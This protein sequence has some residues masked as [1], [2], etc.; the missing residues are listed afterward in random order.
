MTEAEGTKVI[1]HPF[2][3]GLK[4]TQRG[5]R[6]P[7]AS[8][9]PLKA[10]LVGAVLPIMTQYN[11]RS[12]KVVTARAKKLL[13]NLSSCGRIFLVTKEVFCEQLQNI[14]CGRP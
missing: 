7:R 12:Q 10:A 9:P 13:P 3:L 1:L 11:A 4:R 8:K 6:Q 5:R 2:Y 14:R